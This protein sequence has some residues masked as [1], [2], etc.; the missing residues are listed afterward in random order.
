MHTSQ[1]PKQLEF[2]PNSLTLSMPRVL[3]QTKWN[4]VPCLRKQPDG[5]FRLEII[6]DL[7]IE[8]R[9]LRCWP[10][11]HTC[12]QLTINITIILIY[13]NHQST[14]CEQTILSHQ[15]LGFQ[16]PWKTISWFCAQ[17]HGKPSVPIFWFH[18]NAPFFHENELFL[19]MHHFTN[20]IEMLN[21]TSRATL[22]L[23]RPLRLQG[24][25]PDWPPST[26]VN[27]KPRCIFKDRESTVTILNGFWK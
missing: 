5:A 19:H 8:T 1:R 2:I 6:L 25:F 22:F 24:N 4:K 9:S 26:G 15:A 21:E 20:S 14:W 18:E 17:S 3:L 13:Y 10:H 23:P 7:Q 16:I 12:L 11:S 27:F